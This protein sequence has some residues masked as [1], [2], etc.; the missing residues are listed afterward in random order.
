MQEGLA[1]ANAAANTNKFDVG[2]SRERVLSDDE[3]RLIWKATG[4]ADQYGAIV[5]LLMLTACRREEIGALRWSEVD[6]DQAIISLPSARTKNA[7][8]FDLPLSTTALGILKRQ[9]HREGFLDFLFGRAGFT[10]W[11]Q[12][13]A[14]LDRRIKVEPWRLHD[15]RRSA[16]TMMHERLGVAPHIVEASLNHVSG[17]QGGVAGTYNKSVYANE[18]RR[19]FDLWAEHVLA[20]VE[21]RPAKVVALAAR[22]Q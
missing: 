13:K 11:T 9:P 3:L 10:G 12:A 1:D 21:D 19:A 5:R 15:L 17:H 22:S 20:I 7:R 18:K 16:S 2:G 4:D 8:P 6:F 14:A